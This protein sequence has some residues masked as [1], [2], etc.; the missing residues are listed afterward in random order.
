M[1]NLGPQGLLVFM[2][3]LQC[4]SFAHRSTQWERY[5]PGAVLGTRWIKEWEPVVWPSC[6]PCWAAEMRERTCD[7]DH[8]DGS[9]LSP[10][11]GLLLQW[12]RQERRGGMAFELKFTDCKIQNGLRNGEA[13]YFR[14][15]SEGWGPFPGAASF[16][17][18]IEQRSKEEK[19]RTQERLVN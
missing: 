8:H 14:E 3:S 2:T 7:I 9:G 5:M 19:S 10:V 11:P 17:V 16:P 6:V 13:F 1:I 12:R 15:W 4:S 18:W